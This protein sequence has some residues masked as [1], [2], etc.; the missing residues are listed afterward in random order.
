MCHL[1]DHLTQKTKVGY[2]VVAETR[3]G[4]KFSI[5]MGFNY[6]NNR[7][8]I[9]VIKIQNQIGNY[10]H[11]NI[12]TTGLSKSTMIGRTAVFVSKKDALRLAKSI[13]YKALPVKYKLR[14]VKAKVSKDLMSGTYTMGIM[15]DVVAGRH[16]KFLE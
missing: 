15:C 1:N 10:F 2:K 14:V 7:G 12:L 4:E 3:D 6:A 9:P 5:A 11:E 8:N 16:I 13:S